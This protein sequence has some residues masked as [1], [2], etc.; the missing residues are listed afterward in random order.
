M[1]TVA[2]RRV[3]SIKIVLQIQVGRVGIEPTKLQRAAV[4]QTAWTSKSNRPKLRISKAG[5]VQKQNQASLLNEQAERR[6]P[7]T[8]I[9]KVTDRNRTDINLIHSQVPEPM[10][11]GHSST[12]WNRTSG[13]LINSQ[14]EPPTAPPWNEG[15]K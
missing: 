12:G 1:S 11:D 5:G 10:Q 14:S 2:S 8:D 6:K 15:S 3:C 4:L 9:T 13:K 7:K